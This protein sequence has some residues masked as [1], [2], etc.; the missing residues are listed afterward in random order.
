MHAEEEAPSPPLEFLLPSSVGEA[1]RDTAEMMF[2]PPPSLQLD[3]S[4]KWKRTKRKGEED[5]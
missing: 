2:R 4:V 5:L 3:T 1:L